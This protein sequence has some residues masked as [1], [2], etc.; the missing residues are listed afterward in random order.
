MTWVGIGCSL[1]KRTDPRWYL[2]WTFRRVCGQDDRDNLQKDGCHGMLTLNFIVTTWRELSREKSY[3]V[4]SVPRWRVGVDINSHSEMIIC[5]NL[6]IDY[7]NYQLARRD[8]RVKWP[9]DHPPSRCCGCGGVI[10]WLAQGIEVTLSVLI[11]QSVFLAITGQRFCNSIML[12][13]LGR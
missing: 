13:K 3:L 9:T 4:N 11:E 12:I 10:N 6:I 5:V 7:V 1:N 8:G 2:S